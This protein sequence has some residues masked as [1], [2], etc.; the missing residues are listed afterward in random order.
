MHLA[1]MSVSVQSTRAS[2]GDDAIFVGLTRREELRRS[3]IRFNLT[4][5]P[6]TS[7]EVSIHPSLSHLAD[8]ASGAFAA[9]QG[10]AGAHSGPN[11]PV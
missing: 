6:F 2:G 4:Q 5:I 8:L 1:L 7:G 3:V 9:R 11:K 10:V